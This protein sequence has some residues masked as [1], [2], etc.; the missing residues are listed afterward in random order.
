M[1]KWISVSDRLP[2]NNEQVIILDTN[3]KDF[4]GYAK[5]KYCCPDEVSGALFFD[6]I[7]YSNGPDFDYPDVFYY[8]THWMPL[9]EPPEVK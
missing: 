1:S 8:V 5:N 2:E 6:G 9:P 4:S 3:T 7:F